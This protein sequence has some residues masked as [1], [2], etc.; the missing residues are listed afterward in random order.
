MTTI[1]FPSSPTLGQAYSF[2]GKTWVYNNT[3]WALAAYPYTAASETH[4]AASKTTPVDADELFLLDSASS[5]SLAKLTWANIKATLLTY[6]IG[7]FM[8][9]GTS[10]SFRNRKINGNFYVSQEFGTAA[11]TVTAGAALKYVIDQYYAFCTGGDITGQQ[12]VPTPGKTRYR[13]TGSSGNLTT[14]F[15]QR[16]PVYTTA[17]MIGGNATI[18]VKLSSSSIT[19]VNWAAYYASTQDAFGT[20]ASP[21][22]TSIASGSF[23][24]ISSTEATY[25]A[26]LAIPSGADTGIEI[27]YSTGP[28]TAGNTLT[29]GDDQF[30]S[31]AIPPAYI[32]FERPEYSANIARCQRFFRP[33]Y[34]GV[35]FPSTGANQYM[36]VNFSWP[37]M[38]TAPVQGAITIGAFNVATSISIVGITSTGCRVS[39]QSS[40][41][42]D[43]FA[44]D[45]STFLNSRL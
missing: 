10:Q 26:Q 43:C 45:Y 36:D 3:G 5:F 20:L 25:S 13:L 6:L 7:L 17:D 21:T 35:R 37:S 39:L 44:V 14:G 15:A 24:G 2:A 40:G 31:F 28:L 8:L 27:V 22:R 23:T 18:S 30:E 29:F 12:I 9:I 41:A 34:Y 38:R 33:F 16:M 42:G 4:S 11:T 1:S 19:T 32:V